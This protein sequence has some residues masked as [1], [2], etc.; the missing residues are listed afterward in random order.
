MV[1][2]GWMLKA[3]VISL[4][5]MLLLLA[6]TVSSNSKN[7]KVADLQTQVYTPA[8]NITFDV[9][10]AVLVAGY[11]F[12]TYQYTL[13]DNVYQ[14]GVGVLDELDGLL[15]E[16][17]A[18][19]QKYPN[20]LTDIAGNIDGLNAAAKQFRIDNEKIY[21]QASKINEI[22]GRAEKAISQTLTDYKEYW[23]D[24]IKLLTAQEVESGDKTRLTRRI[25]RLL[26]AFPVF[27][28]IGKGEAAVNAIPQ[29]AT[30]NQRLSIG[31]S[32]IKNMEEV[33][34]VIEQTNATTNVPYF[35]NLSQKILDEIAA[36]DLEI[37][38]LL[39]VF[40]QVDNFVA[41]RVEH[42]NLLFDISNK[43]AQTQF[44]LL[45]DISEQSSDR[46]GAAMVF[47]AAII[48]LYVLIA[49]V[50]VNRFSNS[51]VVGLNKVMYQIDEDA[52]LVADV[53]QKSSVIVN[54]L[55]ETSVRQASSLQ[56]ISSSLNEITSMTK[57]TAGNAKNAEL[58]V[59][60]SVSKAKA[61]QEAMSRLQNA[62][63]EIQDSSNETAKILKDIDEIAFQTNLLALNAAVEAARAGEAGKGF[64]VVAEEVRNLAQRS[65]E[66]AKKTA[67]LIQSS[68]KS[69]SRGV[70]LAEESVKAIEEI[71]ESS[72]KIAL[73]VTDITS[74]AE[75]QARGVSQIS[76]SVNGMNNDTQNTAANSQNL[77][78]SSQDLSA[79]ADRMEEL[80]G[81][82][83]GIIDGKFSEEDHRKK[84]H[85]HYF[86]QAPKPDR[87]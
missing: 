7:M 4:A 30:T 56:E 29:A 22:A 35:K 31:N 44:E 81:N 80:V 53:A 62:V 57:Q 45:E 38:E 66:S 64:A 36:Y 70:N 33:K 23:G 50:Y 60:D 63:I 55:S 41:Q 28:A 1:I 24:S 69:S 17:K 51:V 65:A 68:R 67:D 26:G 76:S 16:L 86:L 61:S 78:V 79:Q 11:N 3:F 10:R 46:H 15:G 75:E 19:S 85:E 20:E 13:E 54:S 77:A 47:V 37:K 8:A 25:S 84:V 39:N 43:L 49:I 6:V 74:A 27:E 2:K 59:Q 83:V 12:R 5:F 40:S 32:V 42:Y 21:G 18:L 87:T 48:L 71:T 58:F 82:L 34:R 9:K 52:E 73:I 14:E 72:N